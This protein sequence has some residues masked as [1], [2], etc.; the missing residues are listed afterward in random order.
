MTTYIYPFAAQFT[1]SKKNATPIAAPT[2]DIG[3]LDNPTGALVVSAGSP[4]QLTNLTGFYVYLYSTSTPANYVGCMKTTDTTVDL[5]DIPTFTP[6]PIIQ[7]L[8]AAISTRSSHT[9]AD[10][11]TNTTRTLSS[12]GS[13]IADI[14]ANSVRS[15]TAFAFTPTPSNASDTSAIKAKTDTLPTNP[16]DE[17][18]LEALLASISTYMSIFLAHSS[19]VSDIPAIKAKTDTLPLDP[20]DESLLEA[21]ISAIGGG[22]TVTPADIWSYS[23]RTL[24][25]TVPEIISTLVEDRNIVIYNKTNIHIS[26]TGLGSIVGNTKIWFTVKRHEWTDDDESTLQIEKTVGLTYVNGKPATT[27]SD[28]SL[29]VDDEGLGSITI[30]GKP[31]IVLPAGLYSYDIK[32]LIGADVRLL[33]IGEFAVLH[34]VT[35]H[36]S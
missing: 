21:A 8:D 34:A 22:S 28:A 26:L 9:A 17:T 30:S 1:K 33:S 27:P 12:F 14:W 13:L 31:S 29:V 15:L 19:D 18:L 25:Q 35:D 20:A 24:T 10:V 2:I 32:T 5:Q 7:Y 23:P 16:A 6:N 36:V 4:T 3:N 11:W